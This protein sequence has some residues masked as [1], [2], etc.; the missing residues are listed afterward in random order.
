[1][2]APAA[3]LALALLLLAMVTLA[4]DSAEA[5]CRWQFVC[6]ESGNCQHKP[7]CDST[8]D[9]V[10]IEPP[11]IAPIVPP[12]IKPIQPPVLPPLGTSSC[13]QVRVC[14]NFGQCRWQTVCR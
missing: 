13:D 2:R 6:D 4:A 10:P 9:L 14:N 3:I 11:R 1:M 7:L 5:K 8:I 12:A